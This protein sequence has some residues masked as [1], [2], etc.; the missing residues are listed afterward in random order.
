MLVV[1]GMTKMDLYGVVFGIPRFL[2]TEKVSL[3]KKIVKGGG[4]GAT[5]LLGN[6]SRGRMP[7]MGGF[8]NVSGLCCNG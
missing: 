6:P 5:F 4:L 8:K 1:E 7:V 3:Q 2:S